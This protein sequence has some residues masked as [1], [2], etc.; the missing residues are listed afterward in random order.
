MFVEKIE[1]YN[2]KN[3]YSKFVKN[4]F[5]GMEKYG[6]Q[7]FIKNI[8]V[9]IRFIEIDNYLIPLSFWN[10]NENCYTTSFLS[11]FIY[12][13]YELKNI[14]NL[15]T[16]KLF[17]IVLDLLLYFWKKL[18]IDNIVYV[19][20][21]FLST[22]LYPEWDNGI[23]NKINIF[24]KM[25]YNNKIIFYRS[26]N[27]VKNKDIIN[28]L[29][30]NNFRKICSRQIFIFKKNKIEEY[31]KLK[32]VKNDF[33]IIRKYWLT[34]E[35]VELND[36]SHVLELYNMLYLKKYTNLNPQFT[37]DFIKTT[38]KFKL[39]NLFKLTENNKIIWVIWYFIINNQ[40][41][42]PIFWYDIL[43][44][45]KYNLYSQISNLLTFKSLND[46]DILNSSSWA[47]KFKFSRGWEIKLEYNLIFVPKHIWLLKRKY[48]KILFYLSDKIIEKQLKTNIY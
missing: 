21:F 8:N 40:A 28:T 22:N 41:T 44:D 37:L 10:N 19:N 36:D 32:I 20:N 2:P 31:K 42:T 34:F 7:F 47:W 18:N 16:R 26:L 48:F 35:R 25:N 15:F 5:L 23:V 1:N 39:F 43:K 46:V 11:A 24:I 45:K 9:D 27:Y 17:W 4:Y 33:R 30:D 12:W 3:E 13:K 38:I 14:S 29:E 6:T